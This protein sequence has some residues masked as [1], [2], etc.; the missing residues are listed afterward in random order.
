MHGI[1]ES[2]SLTFTAMPIRTLTKGGGNAGDKGGNYS[3]IGITITNVGQTDICN[4]DL[5]I[6]LP[7]QSTI[8]SLLN[9]EKIGVRLYRLTD[10]HRIGVG[11]SVTPGI[12]V[13]GPLPVISI[14]AEHRCAAKRS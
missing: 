11:E 7:P 9:L 13:S 3:T 1:S 6:I 10:W 14:F 5:S 2:G 4:V 12:T 8:K